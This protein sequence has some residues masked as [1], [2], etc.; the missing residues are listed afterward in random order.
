MSFSPLRFIHASDFQLHQPLAGF[1]HAPDDMRQLL[2]DAPMAAARAV[3]DA[4]IVNSVDFVVLSGGLIDIQRAAPVSVRLL[5][6]QFKRLADKHIRI[7]WAGSLTDGPD[8]WPGGLPLPPN[9]HVFPLDKVE[10]V[11]HVR[12]ARPIASI[13]GASTTTGRIRAGEYRADRDGLFTVG[14]AN[15]SGDAE[16]LIKRSLHYW[17]LGGR[18]D[19]ET[20][21]SEPHIVH[22]AGSPQGRTAQ[23]SGKH[24]AMLVSIDHAGLVRMQPLTT[25][26]VR[27]HREMLVANHVTSDDELYRLM[28]ERVTNLTSATPDRQL[29]IEWTIDV[30]DTLTQDLVGGDLS[31]SLIER[32]NEQFGQRRPGAWTY[33][34]K[35]EPHSDVAAEMYEEDTIL[36]DFLRS[37]REY[38]SNTSKKNLDMANLLSSEALASELGRSLHLGDS[39]SR[40]QLLRQVA[41]IG[42]HMLG[43]AALGDAGAAKIKFRGVDKAKSMT[44]KHDGEGWENHSDLEA[45]FDEELSA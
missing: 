19:A 8:K 15:G 38:R 25:D 5:I 39:L 6:D 30:D 35:P 29:M 44:I 31:A 33:L 16:D 27:W 18:D 28:A 12:D 41:Q 17:A 13:V 11:T 7:Y 22:Y 14:V 36:G 1:A 26:V 10:T 42:V 32:L 9:V 37:L 20:I 3:F 21:S 43:G 23:S 34:L 4:A 40:E 2:V 45:L 24:G